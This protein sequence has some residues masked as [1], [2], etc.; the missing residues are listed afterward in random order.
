MSILHPLLTNP[1]GI[2]EKRPPVL[3]NT[4]ALRAD[5]IQTLPEDTPEFTETRSEQKVLFVCQDIINLSG[6]GT[7]KTMA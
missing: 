7:H 1:P 4:V 3:F 2:K 5:L 6:K